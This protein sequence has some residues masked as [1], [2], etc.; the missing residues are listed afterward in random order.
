MYLFLC[1][2]LKCTMSCDYCVQYTA[3]KDVR[4]INNAVDAPKATEWLLKNKISDKLAVAGGEPTIHPEFRWII[5]SLHEHFNI[6]VT[7]NLF[8]GLFNDMSEFCSW[9]KKYPVRWNTSYHPN[10]G[11]SATLFIGRIKIMKSSG[12][13]VD[14]VSSVDSNY[15]DENTIKK[16]SSAKIGWSMQYNTNP[17]GTNTGNGI[18]TDFDNGEVLPKSSNDIRHHN[19][20]K[21]K[22]WDRFLNNYEDYVEMCGQRSVKKVQCKTDRVI[23]GPDNYIYPCH[24][25]CYRQEKELAYGN[26][27]ETDMVEYKEYTNIINCNIFGHC[28]VCDRSM[29][30]VKKDNYD[31]KKY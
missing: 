1:P 20:H 23:I 7:T 25:T 19:L 4:K 3:N 17:F 10:Q 6:T 8:S 30:L 9:A 24:A 29:V 2:T 26:I 18:A 21:F 13:F 22:D 15:L 31:W 28:D 27:Y 5:E 12:V 11:M 14:Q 16:L